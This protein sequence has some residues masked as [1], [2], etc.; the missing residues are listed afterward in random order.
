MHTMLVQMSIDPARADEV[1]RHLRE[2]I[3][4]WAKAQPDFVSGQWLL[5]HDGACGLGVVNFASDAAATTAAA[6]PKGFPSD[7]KRAWN[8]DEVTVFKQIASA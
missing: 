5:S 2:D 8:V 6:G 1:V 7:E 3:V 4:G